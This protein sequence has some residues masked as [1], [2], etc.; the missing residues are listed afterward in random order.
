MEN[1]ETTVKRT[2]SNVYDTHDPHATGY[3]TPI[4]NPIAAQLRE[5]AFGHYDNKVYA[6][7]AQEAA[8]YAK[9]NIPNVI[10]K[11]FKA[12]EELT[13]NDV[14]NV[15]ILPDKS[16]LDSFFIN[17]SANFLKVIEQ[18]EYKK[19]ACYVITLAMHMSIEKGKN[20]NYF[21]IPFNKEPFVNQESQTVFNE[22]ISSI[23]KQPENLSNPAFTPWSQYIN[24]NGTE[25]FTVICAIAASLTRVVAKDKKILATQYGSSTAQ[26]SIPKKIKEFLRASSPDTFPISEKFLN[27]LAP[28]LQQYGDLVNTL[29]IAALNYK[30]NYRKD[31]TLHGSTRAAL[32]H[33]TF[34]LPLQYN[35]LRCFKY[36][37]TM[38]T[39][40]HMDI[41]GIIKHCINGAT[42]KLFKSMIQFYTEMEITPDDLDPRGPWLRLINRFYYVNLSVKYQREGYAFMIALIANGNPQD[43][44]L[45][46]A[47]AKEV[48]TEIHRIKPLAI[49]VLNL[50]SRCIVDNTG[51]DSHAARHLTGIGFQL[52]E[53]RQTEVIPTQR[54]TLM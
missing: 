21:L 38:E 32:L 33:L 23:G 1:K 19:A 9:T 24:S 13:D 15:R 6:K 18:E 50:F 51:I 52:A 47:V 29:F 35:G 12:G 41:S 4:Y 10:S 17:A 11:A 40:L 27:G 16:L 54:N 2:I 45:Q 3:T 26:K 34:L 53:R 37:K 39:I 14:Y 30:F 48:A 7:L 49:D 44:I 25:A 20:K 28:E 36:I 5:K 22:R 8:D 46:S 42:A 31:T 43:N